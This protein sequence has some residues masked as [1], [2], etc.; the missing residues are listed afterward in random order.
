[1]KKLIVLLFFIQLFNCNNSNKNNEYLITVIVKAPKLKDSL[2][3]SKDTSNANFKY[4]VKPVN[5][6]IKFEDHIASI[7]SHIS[8]IEEQSNDS[9]LFKDESITML[10]ENFILFTKNVTYTNRKFFFK[11]KKHYKT[12]QEPNYLVKREVIN[13]R[14][15]YA[16][17]FGV[18]KNIINIYYL[19]NLKKG[20]KTPI[21]SFTTY[22]DNV[23]ILDEEG[24]F[25]TS[26]YGCC[27]SPDYFELYKLNGDK[28]ISSSNLINEVAIANNNNKKETSKYYFGI[29]FNDDTDLFPRLTIKHPNG[30]TQDII[31][32]TNF[33]DSYYS[34]SYNIYNTKEH[35]KYITEEY[36]GDEYMYKEVKS[37]DDIQI[38]IPVRNKN[39]EI[40]KIDT[41]RIPFKNG[42]PFGKNNKQIMIS[43]NK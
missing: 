34:F 4:F 39:P 7:N 31:F 22:G 32:E 19:S 25:L 26:T 23:K 41:I 28:I 24:Y 8:K 3:T 30:T 5:K 6:K 38:I 10:K 37:I 13:E 35:N 33:L 15:Y 21:Y 12:Y 36:S 2:K 27:S 20:E 11:T 29:L 16:E 43:R 9:I 42:K 40:A 18:T 14:N 1:M 17:G